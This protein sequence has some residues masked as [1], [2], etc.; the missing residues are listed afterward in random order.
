M[1]FFKRIIENSDTKQGRLFDFSIQV[2][3]VLSIVTFSLETLPDLSD[4]MRR[5][6][7]LIEIT[8]V[9]IF[10]IEYVLRVIVAD[11][12]TGFIF[13]F[14]CSCFSQP[15]ESTILNTMCSLILSLLCFTVYGGPL[16]L[17]RRLAT[18]TCTQ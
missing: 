5:W 9:S 17:L 8:T 13:S 15:L 12:K 14:F 18:V 1:E 16:Q 6:L 11:Q 7:R 10:T 4:N 2:L 3:I